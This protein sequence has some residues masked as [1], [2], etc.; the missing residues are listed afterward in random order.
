MSLVVDPEFR[1]LIPAPSAEERAQLETILLAEGC[2]DALVVWKSHD[3]LLD[4]H[5]RLEICERLGLPFDTAEIGLPSRD[6]A[7]AWNPELKR[8]RADV[9]EVL[10]IPAEE[11]KNK[12]TR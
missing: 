7:K 1:G 3:I 10:R 5:N 12:A 11:A 9:E 6:A 4:G 2:R 8:F